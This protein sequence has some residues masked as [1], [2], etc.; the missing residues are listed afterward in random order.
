MNDRELYERA[1]KNRERYRQ[2]RL[3]KEEFERKSKSGSNGK[4]TGK[5]K[6]ITMNDFK[7][8][9]KNVTIA[10][11]LVS[12][13]GQGV[14]LHDQIDNIKND[15]Q[16]RMSVTEV[17]QEVKRNYIADNTYRVNNNEDFAYDWD[18]I[19][20]DQ[21]DILEKY[22]AEVVYA[23]DKEAKYTNID[24]VTQELTEYNS[25]DELM[26]AEGYKDLEDV[27]ESIH[28]NKDEILQMIEEDN[29]KTNKENKGIF[30]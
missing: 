5:K 6:K 29:P 7:H 16:E 11:L 19:K 9:V 1:E 22:P 27:Q 3:R 30:R 20:N 12:T 17:S 8:K 21:E 15:Y 4:R 28:D 10:V 23:T 2:E 18:G 26:K 24:E 25:Y 13:I 14:I